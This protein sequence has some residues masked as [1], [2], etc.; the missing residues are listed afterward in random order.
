MTTIIGVSRFLFSSAR[1]YLRENSRA[2]VCRVCVCVRWAVTRPRE[3]SGQAQIIHEDGGRTRT[4]EDIS[5]LSYLYNSSAIR[6][7]EA[8][9]CNLLALF[10]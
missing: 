7:S 5:H 6:L 9:I 1:V 2:R 3:E 4:E 8:I 10:N